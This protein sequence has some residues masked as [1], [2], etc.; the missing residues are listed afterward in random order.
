MEHTF[1]AHAKSR[2]CVALAFLT[3]SFSGAMACSANLTQ[4]QIIKADGYLEQNRPKEAFA[5]MYP[6]SQQGSGGANQYLA[7]MYE[8]GRGVQK[9]PFMVRHLNWMGAQENDAASMFR[10]GLDF[11]ERGH[12]KD[13]EYWMGRAKD[14][15]NTDAL[16]YLVEKRI[17]QGQDE[18]ALQLI[19]AGI[20]KSIPEVKFIFAEQYEK[21][22]LGL[23]KDP[24]MA[25]R[26]FYSAATDGLPKAMAAIAFYFV[27][28]KHGVQDDVAA[29]A[30]YHKAAK[31]G[32]VESMTAYA[33]MLSNGRG[34]Q[35]DK[36]EAI[37]FWTKA[38]NRGD[39][40]ATRFLSEAGSVGLKTK[41]Q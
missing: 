26:W 2:S 30:W 32:H 10:A 37:H 31:A 20:V 3:L 7:R 8:Q 25:F 36:E 35:M 15:G 38:A 14:C 34:A 17:K 23:Q 27:Q 29:I 11:F 39:A 21:G 9:S 24:H 18:Q 6:L 13:G 12:S 4:E 33:W 41:F 16:R 40:N 22:G 19:Q 1:N 5:V 28:G